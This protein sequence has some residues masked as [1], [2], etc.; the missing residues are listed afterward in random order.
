MGDIFNTIAGQIGKNQGSGWVDIVVNSITS[1]AVN[2]T[3]PEFKQAVVA[4]TL[5]LADHKEDIANLGLYGLTLFLQKIAIGDNN[6]AYLL[7]IETQAT[8]QDLIDGE[9]SDADAIIADKER[10]DA[11]MKTAM[12][13]ALDLAIDG[14]RILIPFLLAML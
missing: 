12:N 7:F 5:T 9:N 1:N 10:R 11:M 13:I 3:Q 6:G 2:I 14:A 4:A 8:F